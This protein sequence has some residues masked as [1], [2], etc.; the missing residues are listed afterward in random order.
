MHLHVKRYKLDESAVRKIINCFMVSM[1]RSSYAVF[2]RFDKSFIWLKIVQCGLFF[3]IWCKGSCG[4]EISSN[5]IKNEK[6]FRQVCDKK[7]KVNALFM[8]GVPKRIRRILFRGS[9]KTSSLIVQNVESVYPKKSIYDNFFTFH[10]I[11]FHKKRVL[12]SAAMTFFT[13]CRV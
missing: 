6:T 11:G 12:I 3:N 10:S 2:W 4:T 1:C 9:Y 7:K 8:E 13:I 5:H